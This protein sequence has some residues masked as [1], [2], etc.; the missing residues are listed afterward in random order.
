MNQKKTRWGVFAAVL[1]ILLLALT[2][3][4][5]ADE[6]AIPSIRIDVLLQE[7]GSAEIT[8]IWEVRGVSDGTE[9]Y[10]ELENMDGMTVHSLSVWEE[11]GAPYQVRDHWDTELTREQKA[12]TCGILP[13]D[14]GYEL[15]WGIGDYGD[16]TYTI[17]Y[18]LVGLVKDYGDYAG[19]YHQF[20]GSLSSAPGSADV[21]VRLAETPLGADNARIWAYGFTGE[22]E[23]PGDGT[24]AAYTHES[25]GRRDYVNLLCRF[26]RS[27]F[28]AA[29]RGDSSFAQLQE[30][31][32]KKNSPAA[33]Y[34]TIGGI[35]VGVVLLLLIFSYAS[36][37]YRLA[38]GTTGKMPRN[39]E[40]RENWTVPLGGDIPAVYA[41]MGLLRKGIA[42]Q[43]LMGAYLIRWQE[44]GLIRV[45]EREVELRR[46]RT[47][48]E[49]AI[50]FPAQRP[51]LQGAEQALYNLL[52]TLADRDCVLYTSDLEEQA[53]HL[54]TALVKWAEQVKSEGDRELTRAGVAG[55]DAKGVLRFTQAGFRQAEDILGFR[56]YLQ[57]LQAAGGEGLAQRELWGDYL[58]FA[59]MLG[60][61]EQ[62]LRGMEQLEPAYYPEFCGRYGCSPYT[63]MYFMTM[64]NHITSASV[65]SNTDGT[66]GAAGSSGGGGFSGG[67]GGGSR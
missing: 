39:R 37:R 12:G 54:F 10:K 42:P 32:E 63:M 13:T 3:P 43:Q 59:T 58:V 62:V 55:P 19:F 52:V 18:T 65:P 31:A 46:G 57:N 56:K 28:P 22:V 47:A 53:E 60:I 23:I 51:G 1:A 20:V 41:A 26:D 30:S 16:H 29:V 9:Y 66:G 4:A 49:E 27:L 2:V 45:E 40:I 61:G 8:E 24:L 25:M 35:A 7:D 34:L 15:C 36:V 14:D 5:F 67:G 50:V 48:T 6:D 33:L 21:T 64:T 44:K 38:D 11:P 17:R